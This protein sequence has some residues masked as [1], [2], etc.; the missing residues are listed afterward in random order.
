M[1]SVPAAMRALGADGLYWDEIDCVDYRGP[2]LTE[3]VWD[4]RSC[5]LRPD[6]GVEKPV[7]LVNLLSD[8]VKL[9]YARAGG[10]VLGNG[11][12]TTR[13]FQDRLDTRMVEAQHNDTWGAFAQ[14]STPLGYISARTDWDIVVAKID[15]GLLI[16]GIP[17][18]YPHGIVA[19][20][21]PFTPEY[22]QAGTLRG[23]ERIV[24][25]RSGLHGWTAATGALKLYRYDASG[26]EHDAAWNVEEKDGGIFVQVELGPREA[27][28]IERTSP[29]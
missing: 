3:G 19:R 5:R 24:T 28:V 2:R 9:D 14:L 23:R 10:F 12:P 29:P 13:Q 16:A 11:P 6:G 7:G 27:A 4:R 25:T 15:E 18:D 17:L 20:M 8:S 22:I 1:T 21:F 26:K